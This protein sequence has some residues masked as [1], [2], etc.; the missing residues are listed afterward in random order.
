MPIIEWNNLFLLGLKQFDDDHQQ[1]V[2]L[3]NKTYDSF[4]NN[5]PKSSLSVVIDELVDYAIYHFAEEEHWMKSTGY[6]ELEMHIFQHDI[7]SKR[8]V[9]FQSAYQEGSAPLTLEL[10]TFLKDW[11]S[12]HILVTD[13]EFGFYIASKGGDMLISRS[14]GSSSA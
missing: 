9:D 13:K 6:P 1:L 4:I 11:L 14:T 8:V 5:E 2:R 7:F 12:D 3:L 10:L